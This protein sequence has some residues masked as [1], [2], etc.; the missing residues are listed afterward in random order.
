MR[1]PMHLSNIHFGCV[2]QM[3]IEP[4]VNLIAKLKPNIVAVS[5]VFDT[6][7]VPSAI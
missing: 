4:L 7:G 6:T 2:E 1:T 5:G 3:V